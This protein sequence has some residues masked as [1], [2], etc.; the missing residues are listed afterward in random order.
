[1]ENINTLPIKVQEAKEQGYKVI[2]FEI[3]DKHFYLRKPTKTELIMYQ[4]DSIKNKGSVAMRSEKFIR[5]LFVG[6]NTEE[7]VKY[8]DEKPLVLGNLME[9]VLKDM[10]AD[11]NFMATEI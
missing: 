10:G 3:E 11:E 9:E 1:M 5:K 2:H 7:F 6:E 8:L 4:D